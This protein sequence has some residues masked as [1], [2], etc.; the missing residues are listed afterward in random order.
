MFKDYKEVLKSERWKKLKKRYTSL[1][2]RYSTL[3]VCWICRKHKN[4]YSLHHKNY[5]NLG[6]EQWGKDII[7][8]CFNCHKLLHFENGIKLPLNQITNG[9]V[10]RLRKNLTKNNLN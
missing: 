9:R 7:R 6:K 10:K 1:G 4:R 3:W 2:F 5:N 8:I